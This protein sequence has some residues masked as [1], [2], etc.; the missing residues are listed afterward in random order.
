MQKKSAAFE[1]NK[2]EFYKS[3]IASTKWLRCLTV[4]YHI[5]K[6]GGR[7]YIKLGTTG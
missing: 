4:W 7:I 1:K 5:R 3:K 2:P 6:I